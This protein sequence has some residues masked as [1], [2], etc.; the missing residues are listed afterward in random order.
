M[1]VIGLIVGFVLG[2]VA[3]TVGVVLF[4][5]KVTNMTF[6][7]MSDCGQLLMDAGNNRESTIVWYDTKSEHACAVR[8]PEK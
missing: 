2:M 5:K 1:L 6:D 3:G 8:L 7:E 4:S